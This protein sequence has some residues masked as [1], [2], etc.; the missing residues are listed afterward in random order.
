MELPD[1][2]AP[3]FSRLSITA[4]LARLDQLFDDASPLSLIGS[5]MGGYLAARWAEQNPGRV[6]RL[7]LLCPGF[8]L[9]TRWPDLI[10]RDAFENWQTSGWHPFPNGAGI[11]EKV[12]F[13]LIEDALTH[14]PYPKATCPTTII[15]GDQDETV[16]VETSKIYVQ[17]Y[18]AVDLK[19]VDDDHRLTNSIDMIATTALTCLGISEGFGLP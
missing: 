14:P 15:H 13:G 16:P 8:G 5:S 6:D 18:P 11:L 7:L 2:N 1:L 17:N 3:S 19:I 9:N 10:G 4:M 12:H